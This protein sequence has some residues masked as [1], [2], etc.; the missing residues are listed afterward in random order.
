MQDWSFTTYSE[1]GMAVLDFHRFVKCLMSGKLYACLFWATI[2]KSVCS[3]FVNLTTNSYYRSLSKGSVQFYAKWFSSFVCLSSQ[4]KIQSLILSAINA[5]S[6][7][8]YIFP[9][10]IIAVTTRW[11]W[12]PASPR[13]DYLA[14]DVLISRIG[15]VWVVLG[16][17]S[18]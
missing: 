11:Y 15:A 9:L 1:P 13:V 4:L 6:L 17:W 12:N 16:C 7:T 5:F 3:C 2:R 18:I 8:I 14:R 10:I